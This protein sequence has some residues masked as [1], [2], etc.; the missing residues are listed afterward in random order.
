MKYEQ[1]IDKEPAMANEPVAAYGAAVKCRP[2]QE[3]HDFDKEL[4][5]F[6]DNLSDEQLRKMPCQFTEEELD[7]EIRLSEESGFVSNED[8]KKM[9]AQWGYVR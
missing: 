6:L 1:N 2:A 9:F 3:S 8:V 7:E 4:D 5:D